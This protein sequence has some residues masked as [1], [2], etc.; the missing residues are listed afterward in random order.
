MFRK[1][2]RAFLLLILVYYLLDWGFESS[3]GLFWKPQKAL[4]DTC[5]GR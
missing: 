2:G 3:L 5:Y 4:A 1:L